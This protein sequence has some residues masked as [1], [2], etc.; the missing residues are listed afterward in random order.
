MQSSI[1]FT[2]IILKKD[3][4]NESDKPNPIGHYAKAKYLG[5][6]YVI[7]NLPRDLSRQLDRNLLFFIDSTRAL[8]DVSNLILCPFKKS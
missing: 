7:E 4:Y 3:V 1:P 6:K 2:K 8:G 5:E